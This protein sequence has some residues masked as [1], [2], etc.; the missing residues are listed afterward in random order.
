MRVHECLRVKAQP[1]KLEER[2]K[3]YIT[4]EKAL[5]QLHHVIVIM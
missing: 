2:Q 4:L 1:S 5:L 3:I